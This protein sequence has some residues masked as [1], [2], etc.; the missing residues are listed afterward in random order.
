MFGCVNTIL[1]LIYP[2]TPPS[3]KRGYFAVQVTRSFG[4]IVAPPATVALIV[5][6]REIEKY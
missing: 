3:M 2:D 4:P 1:R 6:F 5:A